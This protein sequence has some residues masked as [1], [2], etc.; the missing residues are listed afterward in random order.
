[1]V[2]KDRSVRIP[3]KKSDE[4]KFTRSGKYIAVPSLNVPNSLRRA[5][6]VKTFL[7]TRKGA[8]VT[9]EGAY[10]RKGKDDYQLMFVFTPQA[11][12]EPRLDFYRTQ[13]AV[14]RK[15]FKE[16]FRKRLAYALRTAR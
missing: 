1:M 10:L 16:N 12:I 11:K 4:A 5:G 9:D 8:F 14:C 6:G 2:R 3:R 7:R 13:M 15:A